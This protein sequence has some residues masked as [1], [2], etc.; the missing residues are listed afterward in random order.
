MYVC[1]RRATAFS[2]GRSSKYGDLRLQQIP[3]RSPKSPYEIWYSRKPDPSNLRVSGCVAYALVPAAKR[4][5]FDDQTVKMRFLGSHKGHQGYKLMEQ[6]GTCVF[7]RT[8]VTFDEYNFRLSPKR[9]GRDVEMLTGRSGC[10]QQWKTCEPAS[11]SASQCTSRSASQTASDS[12]DG[13]CTS[14]TGARASS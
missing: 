1:P 14:R 2:L 11:R 8:D 5:M 3:Q 7:Y 9:A 6:G 12:G 10:R 13:G 4:R